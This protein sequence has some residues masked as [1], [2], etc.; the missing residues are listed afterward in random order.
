MQGKMYICFKS[1]TQ[2]LP[3]SNKANLHPIYQFKSLSDQLSQS[4]YLETRFRKNVPF[5]N[6]WEIRVYWR[7]VTSALTNKHKIVINLN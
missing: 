6:L 7:Q 3:N 4:V 2:Y 1:S 5:F